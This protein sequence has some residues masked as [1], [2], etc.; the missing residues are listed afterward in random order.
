MCFV[1]SQVRAEKFLPVLQEAKKRGLKL[2]LHMA[3]VS[4]FTFMIPTLFHS[5]LHGIFYWCRL[6]EWMMRTKLWWWCLQIALDTESICT[7]LMAAQMSCSPL[8]TMIK[9]LLVCIN[10]PW[11]LSTLNCYY[12]FVSLCFS[13]ICLTS[14]ITTGAVKDIKDHCFLE[15]KKINHPCAI[16]VS[17]S[18][19]LYLPL[20]LMIRS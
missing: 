7:L 4:P 1:L 20:S 6:R 3:E 19:G 8:L 12:I 2:T 11:K 18:H 16:C 13:E 9:Y 15:W 14:N 10:F 5:I 17:V